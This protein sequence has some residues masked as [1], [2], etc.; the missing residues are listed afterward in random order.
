LDVGGD[1]EGQGEGDGDDAD[2]QA[3]D[4]VAQ[5]EPAGVAFAK[6]MM[7]LGVQAP[8]RERWGV[9]SAGAALRV[10]TD[11]TASV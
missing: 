1:R 10:A 3:G 7:N 11:M 5:E 8:R 2:G 9:G 6:Q 4:G